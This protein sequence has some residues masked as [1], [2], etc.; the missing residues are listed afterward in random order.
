VTPARHDLGVQP[1]PAGWLGSG[2]ESLQG[3]REA[4]ALAITHVDPE[5]ADVRRALLPALDH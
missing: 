5:S 2:L 4:R 1:R 3:I